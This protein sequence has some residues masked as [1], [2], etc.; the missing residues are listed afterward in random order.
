MGSYLD[1]WRAHVI[2]EM[3]TGMS[4][5]RPL[6]D[7]LRGIKLLLCNHILGP[8]VS[9]PNYVFIYYPFCHRK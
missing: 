4:K 6:W 2:A 7:I 9:L 5:C 8:F 3:S 1:Q